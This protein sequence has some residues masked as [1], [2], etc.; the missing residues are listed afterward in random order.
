V[1]AIQNP[2]Y[3]PR[4][5]IADALVA[6]ADRLVALARKRVADA[7]AELR[8]AEDHAAEMRARRAAVTV[9]CDSDGTVA[10]GNVCAREE[11]GDEAI[12]IGVV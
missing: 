11:H 7:A 8:H 6:N 10:P 12:W 1:S 5:E 2:R 4:A 9:A 3:A